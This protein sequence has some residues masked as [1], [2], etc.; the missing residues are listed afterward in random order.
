MHLNTRKCLFTGQTLK[1]VAHR[2]RVS[3]HGIIQNLTGHGHEQLALAC[4]SRAWTKCSSWCLLWFCN[5]VILAFL[6]S[7]FFCCFCSYYPLHI[8]HKCIHFS[9]L[10]Y[11]FCF[12]RILS[13]CMSLG[14]KT[15]SVHPDLSPP[16]LFQSMCIPEAFFCL[17]IVSSNLSSQITEQYTIF[18]SLNSQL[19]AFFFSSCVPQYQPFPQIFYICSQIKVYSK[20]IDFKQVA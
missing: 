8:A 14:K 10:L 11:F 17:L 16:S 2:G 12:L 19:P 18:C 7:L 5:S 9:R 4:L 15:I 6:L 13:F 20:G 3:I 1:Q